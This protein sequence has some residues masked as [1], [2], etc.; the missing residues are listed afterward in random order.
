MLI[1]TSIQIHKGSPSD[2]A[3]DIEKQILDALKKDKKETLEFFE[4]LLPK[5]IPE[6]L[7]EAEVKDIPTL[8]SPPSAP[9]EY[10]CPPSNNYCCVV[11]G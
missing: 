7:V 6:V 11:D 4:K 10:E 9:P 8:P 5:K 1:T 2:V 3:D